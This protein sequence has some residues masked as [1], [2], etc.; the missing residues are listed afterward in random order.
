V[1]LLLCRMR[2]DARLARLA[3]CPRRLGA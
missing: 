3:A 1:E 2:N